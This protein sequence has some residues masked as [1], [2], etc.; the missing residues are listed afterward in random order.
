MIQAKKHEKLREREREAE[1]CTLPKP[2]NI[3]VYTAWYSKERPRKIIMQNLV[4]KEMEEKEEEDDMQT[5]LQHY[6]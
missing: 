2:N 1:L 4:K 5:H 3:E 6:Y